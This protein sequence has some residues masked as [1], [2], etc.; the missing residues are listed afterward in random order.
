M[1]ILYSNSKMYHDHPDVERYTQAHL[2]I[3]HKKTLQI[4]HH[5]L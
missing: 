5:H 1:V 3:Y 4:L 2:D